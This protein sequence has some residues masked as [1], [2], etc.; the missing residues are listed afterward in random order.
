MKL[1]LKP[2]PRV[3]TVGQRG[4]IQIK[5]LGEIEL[6]PNEMITFVTETG[7]RFDFTRKDWGYYATPSVNRRLKHEGFKTAIVRNQQGQVY[8]M[9][10]DVDCLALFEKYCRDQVQTV[11]SWLDEDRLESR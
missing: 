7:K 6:A 9:V 5:D 2:T 11:I 8:V 1:A 10:V 4:E 3:F